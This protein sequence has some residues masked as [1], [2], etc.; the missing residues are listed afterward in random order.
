[1]GMYNS[2]KNTGIMKKLLLLFVCVLTTVS[3]ISAA[4]PLKTKLHA[5]FAWGADIGGAIDLTGNDMSTLNINAAF[6][7]RR[8]V[9]DFIGVGTGMSSMVTNSALLLPFSG[10]LRSNFR[11]VQSRWF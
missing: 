2:H 6:G 9:I 7:Y 4:E 5:G 11:T 8:G 3:Y 10:V 1:M